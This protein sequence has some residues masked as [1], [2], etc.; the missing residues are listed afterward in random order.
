[1]VDWIDDPVQQRKIVEFSIKLLSFSG[2]Y[3][4]EKK[5]IYRERL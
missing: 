4:K 3:R 1:V 5:K 2:G